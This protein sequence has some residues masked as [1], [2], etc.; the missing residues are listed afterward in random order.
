M[1]E[2]L[3]NEIISGTVEDVKFR[4]EQNRRNKTS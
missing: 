1:S 2:E 3:K 4:N